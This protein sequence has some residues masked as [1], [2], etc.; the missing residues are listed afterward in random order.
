MR[1]LALS[2][3]MLMS[4]A[5]A[6]Q[7]APTQAL[8]RQPPPGQ[9]TGPA[10]PSTPVPGYNNGPAY[11]YDDWEVPQGFRRQGVL[12]VVER[13]Q[14]IDRLARMEEQLGRALE[15]ADR[16]NSRDSRDL[17]DALSKV[18]AEMN[19][20][21]ADVSNAPDL[22]VFRRRSTPP[23]PPPAPVPV[24][25]PISEGQLQQLLNAINKES[26]GDGKLRV[27]ESASPTQFFLVSQVQ[28]IL[29][30]FSFGDDK[31]DAV[32]TLWP[33]VLDRENG[34]QLYGSFNF[35]GEKDKLRD[36]IGR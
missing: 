26:F 16:N 15:R 9:A 3:V 12:V 1:A 14:I 28:K 10:Q 17:R 11:G 34:Y 36:I 24:A 31:L 32:R 18:R 35:Q 7:T 5:A 33:R 23:P 13:E 20:V 27:L 6:A 2:V 4:A 22:R 8:Q 25:Q 29:Q 30:R 19:G 21:R